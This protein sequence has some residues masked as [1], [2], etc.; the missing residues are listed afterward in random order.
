[1]NNNFITFWT[2]LYLLGLYV[3]IVGTFF[4]VWAIYG[5][6]FDFNIFYV[7]S[8]GFFLAIDSWK[9]LRDEKRQEKSNQKFGY[10]K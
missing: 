8:L 10:S 9:I 2:A 5:H 6:R 7:T 3:T 1:M 4:L